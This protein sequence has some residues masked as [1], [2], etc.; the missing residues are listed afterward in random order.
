MLILPQVAGYRGDLI[1]N[2]SPMVQGDT[3]DAHAQL[4]ICIHKMV[5]RFDHELQWRHRSGDCA[6]DPHV[7]TTG[8]IFNLERLTFGLRCVA[9]LVVCDCFYL[10]Y[11][12]PCKEL[13]SVTVDREWN[14]TKWFWSDIWLW[15]GKPSVSALPNS[16]TTKWVQ[17]SSCKFVLLQIAWVHSADD[18]CDHTP[19][20]SEPRTVT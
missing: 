1:S 12:K 2:V 14:K 10:D 20:E 4:L 3:V 9:R 15:F 18:H 5:I 11:V 19:H 16:I 8:L 13:V 7:V 17:P 6:F